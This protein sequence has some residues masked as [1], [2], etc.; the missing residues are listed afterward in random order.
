MHPIALLLAAASFQ[1]GRQQITMP[2]IR[3]A[4]ALAEFIRI[5]LLTMSVCSVEFDASWFEPRVG[6][7]QRQRE[8]MLAAEMDL[9]PND[10]SG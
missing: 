8:G 7:G 5:C 3:W 10:G 9:M 6:G 2:E 4:L 1:P